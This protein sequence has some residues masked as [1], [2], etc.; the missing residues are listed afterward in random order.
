MDTLALHTLVAL[1]ATLFLS[2]YTI[3]RFRTSY[4]VIWWVTES[5]AGRV[6][7]ALRDN[8]QRVQVLGLDTQRFKLLSFVISGTLAGMLGFVILI[9]AGSSAPRFAESS[10]TIW[11]LLLGVIGGQVIRGGGVPGGCFLIIFSPS[12]DT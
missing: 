5:S 4:L 8:E 2:L 11:L 12:R 7:A 3:L 9:A 10:V 1:Y 6:F